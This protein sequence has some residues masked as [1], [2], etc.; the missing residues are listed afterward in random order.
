MTDPAAPTVAYHRLIDLDAT[1]IH[2]ESGH[3]VGVR[4]DWP[5]CPAHEGAVQVCV[6]FAN[7]P[8]GPAVAAGSSFPGENEGRRWTRD[9]ETL[10]AMTLSPSV[11]CSRCGHWH[12]FVRAGDTSR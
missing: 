4:F 6:L 8:D 10:D 3:R 5:T 7:P 12:G 9:G 1:W 2:D 11:D